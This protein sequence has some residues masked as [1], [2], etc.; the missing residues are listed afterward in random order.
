MEGSDGVEAGNGSVDG[1]R[2][3]AEKSGV[4]REGALKK[5]M[6]GGREGEYSK[7]GEQR[8]W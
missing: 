4:D 3:T 5:W 6:C 8:V 1:G 7:C 2:G